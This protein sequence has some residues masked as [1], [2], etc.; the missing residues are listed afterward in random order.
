M[1][2]AAPKRDDLA[3]SRVIAGLGAKVAIPGGTTALLQMLQQQ[4][5][6][7]SGTHYKDRLAMFQ[8]LIDPRKK[9]GSSS[10]LPEPIV[11]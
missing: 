2:V 3:V 7:V 5:L 4:R 10:T 9:V 8:C 11:L 1:E 6:L